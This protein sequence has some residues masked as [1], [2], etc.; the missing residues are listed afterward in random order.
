LDEIKKN[1]KFNILIE[2]FD[3]EKKNVVK[4]IHKKIFH[5]N[6]FHEKKTAVDNDDLNFKIEK[7]CDFREKVLI[8]FSCLNKLFFKTFFV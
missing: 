4:N 3:I 5:Q 1:Q 6:S 2:K 7:I 8:L